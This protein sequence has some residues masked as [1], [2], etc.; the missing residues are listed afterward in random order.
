LY[1]A[2]FND[3]SKLNV[4]EDL[5]LAMIRWWKLSICNWEIFLEHWLCA[6]KWRCILHI[7]LKA[8]KASVQNNSTLTK[9][10]NSILIVYASLNNGQ[11]NYMYYNGYYHSNLGDVDIFG[12]YFSCQDKEISL[13]SRQACQNIYEPSKVDGGW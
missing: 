1:S 8:K 6:N 11:S 2:S 5:T 10:C 13:P 9:V 12:Y 3:R 7:K 4:V